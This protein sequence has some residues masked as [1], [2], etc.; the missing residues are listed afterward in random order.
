MIVS[1][2]KGGR[3]AD[4]SRL[5][6]EDLRGGEAIHEKTLALNRVPI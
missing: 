3:E 2:K 5:K 6:W 1:I 4:I